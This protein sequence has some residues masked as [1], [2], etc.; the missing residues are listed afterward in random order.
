MD[1]RFVL[2]RL[3]HDR[4][5]ADPDRVFFQE[6][7]GR[8]FTY[9]QL[10]DEILTWADALR[11]AGVGAGDVVSV[12]IPNTA[13]TVLIWMGIAWA[14]AVE[15]PVNSSFKGKM[16]SDLLIASKARLLVVHERFVDRV[17]A[18]IADMSKLETIVVLGEH[19]PAG[20]AVTFVTA[21]EFL[22]GAVPRQ[23]G[24]YFPAA[25]D[26]ASIVWTSGTTG[27]SKGCLVSWTQLMAMGTGAFPAQDL[28]QDDVIY[29]PFPMFY[30][31]GKLFL[32][33]FAYVGGRVV[34]K[35]RFSTEA[36]WDEIREYGCTTSPLNPATT[37]F[38]YRQPP[39]PDDAD[40][41]LRNILLAPLIPE[42]DEFCKRFGV[43]AYT[44]YNSTEIS[45]PIVSSWNP[46][47]R[48]AC[49]KVRPGYQV[50]VVDENDY[51]VAPGEVGELVVRA[52]E[53]WTLMTGY[54]DRPDATAAA[55]RNLWF[56][57]GDAFTYDTDGYYYFVDRKKD[58]IRRRGQN[59]SSAEVE[60]AVNEHP[61]IAECAV[62][63]APSEWGE[64]EVRAVVTLVPGKSAGPLEIF[65]FVRDRLPRF[66]LPRFI[67]IFTEMPKT[68]TEKILK[69]ELRQIG[70][71]ERTWDRDA[72][73]V[74]SDYE[75]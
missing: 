5:A 34:M 61:A 47:N 28:T 26:T 12:M 58:A 13:E 2:P 22:R 4:A 29:S 64:D 42:I 63:A 49:G 69:S 40:T 46:E 38:L 71:T 24:L 32:C 33:L 27:P 45:C 11:R 43:R 6:A 20:E 19:A 3:L 70:V 1:E 72:A 21:A 18:V 41:P 35:E 74:H 39:G 75:G 14:G 25:H 68:N 52:D 31:G 30:V 8:T 57:T 56:H 16:L 15:L 73:G 67:D 65:D 17:R 36:Y 54:Y 55:W 51:E 9:R 66:M 48:K 37:Y 50:A 60:A 10:D 62:V 59:I 7:G 23:D 44:V 53:P